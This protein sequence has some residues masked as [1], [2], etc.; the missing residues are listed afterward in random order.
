MKSLIFLF[1]V[2]FA[3][4]VCITRVT[5]QEGIPLYCAMIQ[6]QYGSVNK[7]FSL[8]QDVSTLSRGKIVEGADGVFYVENYPSD[9]LQDAPCL[10]ISKK[11]A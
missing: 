11:P 5:A 3:F 10:H 4:L 6:M 7:L 8:S 1:L 2:A 9:C